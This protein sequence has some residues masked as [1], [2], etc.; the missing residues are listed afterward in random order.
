[1]LGKILFNSL[2]PQISLRAAAAFKRNFTA[3][4]KYL[5]G[6]K[7]FR[8]SPILVASAGFGFA[9]T[10]FALAAEDGWIEVDA[11]AVD[12][13]EDGEMK[14][15]S[16]I[17][18]SFDYDS[19]DMDEMIVIENRL[20]RRFRQARAKLRSSLLESMGNSMQSQTAAPMPARLLLSRRIVTFRT[21]SRFVSKSPA[22]LFDPHRNRTGLRP[23]TSR[24]CFQYDAALAHI[25]LRAL[26]PHTN[27]CKHSH[28]RPNARA[29]HPR[30]PP[31]VRPWTRA[32]WWGAGSC[33]RG[34]TPPSPSSPAPPSTCPP[35]TPSTSTPCRSPP[36][37]PP[38]PPTHASLLP[39]LPT[40]P[41]VRVRVR[42][43]YYVCACVCACVHA[44]ARRCG[45]GGSSCG[46][47][48]TPSSDRCRGGGESE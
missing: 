46:C 23:P 17:H 2:R 42:L 10:G 11:L 3:G 43:S 27:P 34:T 9:S 29:P 35:A 32:C 4:F 39:N 36:R 1:M 8:Y 38:P 47:P 20:H 31:Q 12:E 21:Y 22:V 40:P 28:S 7:V 19:V 13:L 16:L 26:R 5:K 15:V 37:R 41:F 30:R 48:P 24:F 18:L 33:A 6:T 25:H 45:R 44:C 14:A